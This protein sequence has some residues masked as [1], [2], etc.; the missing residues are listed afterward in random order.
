MG[1]GFLFIIPPFVR[2]FK[3][4]L[5][6]RKKKGETEQIPAPILIGTG[7]DQSYKE[8]QISFVDHPDVSSPPPPPSEKD[9]QLETREI[10]ETQ[11]FE[12]PKTR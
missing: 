6:E 3:A 9:T 5:F 10:P 1:L 11:E 2:I 4:D 8:L 7:T 12:F